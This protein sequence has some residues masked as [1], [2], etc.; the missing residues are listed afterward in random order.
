MPRTGRESGVGGGACIAVRDGRLRVLV[1]EERRVSE[2][3]AVCR[4]K[5]RGNG[6]E[7][8]GNGIRFL[9]GSELLEKIHCE[10]FRIVWRFVLR[11]E[12]KIG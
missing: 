11:E 3:V 4:R 6:R 7:R 9:T 8:E 12:G 5:R 2:A 10:R 1:I